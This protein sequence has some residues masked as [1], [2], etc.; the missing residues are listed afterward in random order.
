MTTTGVAVDDDTGWGF[1]ETVGGT[2]SGRLGMRQAE[3]Q[4]RVQKCGEA[5]NCWCFQPFDASL[6]PDLEQAK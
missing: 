3:S 5:R 4:P 6:K 2:H 1:G